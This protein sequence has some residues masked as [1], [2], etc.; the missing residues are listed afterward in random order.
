VRVADFG[1][2]LNLRD[3]GKMESVLVCGT[4]GY[5]APESISGKG[6]SSKTDIFSVGVILFAMLTK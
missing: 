4:P 5:I 6:I 2:A 1:Y 3:K